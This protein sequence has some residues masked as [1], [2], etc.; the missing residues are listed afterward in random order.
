M[1]I[2][3]KLKKWRK[4]IKKGVDSQIKTLYDEGVLIRRHPN[5][6]RT[7]ERNDTETEIVPLQ[8]SE[9]RT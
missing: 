9:A 8:F 4:K 5:I 7:G 6:E 3:E 1:M 2:Q